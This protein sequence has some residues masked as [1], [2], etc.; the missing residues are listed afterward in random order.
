M[1]H[2]KKRYATLNSF[3]IEARDMF[4]NTSWTVW[5]ADKQI[6][7]DYGDGFVL[8]GDKGVFNK[9]F[10]IL[11]EDPRRIEWAAMINGELESEIKHATN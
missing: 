3:L 11:F 2:M 10:F 1:V 6:V 8:R 4:P 9:E 7:K 5:Q